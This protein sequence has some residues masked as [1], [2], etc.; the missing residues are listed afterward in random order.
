[1]F[2]VEVCYDFCAIP[3]VSLPR[4]PVAAGPG[5]GASGRTGRRCSLW[6]GAALQAQ[7][8]QTEALDGRRRPPLLGADAAPR[9][10]KERKDPPANKH[11]PQRVPLSTAPT[12]QWCVVCKGPVDWLNTLVS[13]GFVQRK[14]DVCKLWVRWIHTHDPV[15]IVLIFIHLFT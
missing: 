1:M 11:R 13:V 6:T 8:E 7:A 14:H 15:G 10:G 9:G 2:W 4:E 5:G 3:R 12:A